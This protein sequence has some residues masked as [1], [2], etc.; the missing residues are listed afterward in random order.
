MVLDNSGNIYL[1]GRSRSHETDW[2]YLTVKYNENGDLLWAK[3]F[4]GESDG[5]DW[6]YALTVGPAG[7]VY[8][9]GDS[10]DDSSALDIVTVKYHP[11]GDTAWV[12]RFDGGFNCDDMARGIGVDDL[13]NVYVTGSSYD[14]TTRLDYV[15]LKYD[16]DGT[17]MWVRKF[18]G[19]ADSSDEA[20]AMVVDNLGNVGVTGYSI[21]FDTVESEICTTANYLT[22]TYDSAG[23]E[24]WSQAYGGPGSGEELPFSMTQDRCRNLYVTGKGIFAQAHNFDYATVKYDSDGNQLWAQPYNGPGNDWDVG[25]ALATDD[26]GFVYVTGGSTDN[27]SSY[28]YATVKY[29][30]DGTQL[31]VARFNGV[32]NYTDFAHAIAVDANGNVYVTGQ[33]AQ[34][35]HYPTDNDFVTIKYDS[36]GNEAWVRSYDGPWENPANNDDEACAIAVDS[37]G[38]IL[39]AGSSEDTIGYYDFLLLSYFEVDVRGDIN[40]DQ[41]INISDVIYALNYL[42]KSGPVPDPLQWADVNCDEIVDISDVVFLINYL[43]RLGPLPCEI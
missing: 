29:T 31:W 3:I 16:P 6:P 34:A 11:S 21:C 5:S 15:T 7:D 1:T 28:D 13:G 19:T 14:T 42:Y 40:D 36:D 8:V 30:P 9:T 24:L 39:V 20:R 17:E 23:S 33:S 26:S 4:N 18:N 25:Y 37:D 22:I 2:D 12:R 27:F 43:F 10:R 32:G 35:S 41:A 38:H